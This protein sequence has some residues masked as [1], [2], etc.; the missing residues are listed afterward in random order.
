[1]ACVQRFV[2]FLNKN[3]YIQIALEGKS[4]CAAARDAMAVLWANPARVSFVNGIGGAFIFIGK[5][6]ISIATVVV[7]YYIMT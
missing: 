4:F 5:A 6:F 1:M 7:C 3:A 2:E